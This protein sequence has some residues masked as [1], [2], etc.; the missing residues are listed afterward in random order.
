MGRS[1]GCSVGPTVEVWLVRLGIE[2]WTDGCCV[3]GMEEVIVERDCVL[4]LTVIG[5]WV[6]CFV[7]PTVGAWLIALTEGWTV[8]CTVGILVGA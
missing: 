7:G 5:R 1:V 2:D 8:L 6:G 4:G 3:G